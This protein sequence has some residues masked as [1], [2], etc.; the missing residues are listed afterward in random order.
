MA[1]RKNPTPSVK[2]YATVSAQTSR[3]LEE[4]V[5][6]YGNNPSEVAGYLI[7]R[8][9]DD[10]LRAHVITRPARHEPQKAEG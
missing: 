3:H 1:R 6:S 9:I 5:G 4:L 7:Q 8:G 2:V 10:L